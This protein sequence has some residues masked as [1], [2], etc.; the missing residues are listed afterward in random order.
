MVRDL[1]FIV[2]IWLGQ[3]SF[4]QELYEKPAKLITK[5]PFRQL[6]GGIILVQAKFN[7]VA[8][9]LN[10]I[11]DTGSGAISLDSSTTALPALM[12]CKC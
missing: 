6:N 3:V 9:P 12:A 11:L 7:S 4:G 10:F 2:F 1:L 8:Q 5:F